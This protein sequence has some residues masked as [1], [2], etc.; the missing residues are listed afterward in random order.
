MKKKRA[1]ECCENGHYTEF[2]ETTG[3]HGAGAELALSGSRGNS[4]QEL[5][6]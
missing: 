5:V 6:L 1:V 4:N 2:M 3:K